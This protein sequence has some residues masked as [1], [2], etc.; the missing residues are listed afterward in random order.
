MNDYANPI[1][2]YIRIFTLQYLSSKVPE[3]QALSALCYTVEV[4][5]CNKRETK[6]WVSLVL[7]L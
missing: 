4:V 5:K 6:V 7:Y 1:L 3:I 2:L